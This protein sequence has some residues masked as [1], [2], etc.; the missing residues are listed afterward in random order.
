MVTIRQSTVCRLRRLPPFLSALAAA[1]VPVLLAAGPLPGEMRD[2]KA[3][4]IAKSLMN[5]MGGEDAWDNVQ[6]VRYDFIV[7]MGGK[8][9]VNRSHLWD[10]WNGRYRLESTTRDGKSQVV[11]FNVGDRQGEVYVDGAKIGGAAKDEALKRAYGAFINDMYWLA[12]PWKWLDSGV[13]LQYLGPSE[14]AGKVCDVVELSFNDVGLTPGDRYRAFVSPETHLMTRWEY[15]LQSGNKGA[16]SW[17]YGTHN[18][19]M[20]AAN[21]IN[22]EGASINMGEVAVLGEVEDGFFTDPKR[23]L[24]QLR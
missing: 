23:R 1:V 7:S 15:T 4:E 10:K 22:A 20:L 24:S 3:M 5:A 17:E 13:S 11:L 8:T 2:P 9:K 6:F 14:H 19:V 18:G 12:M 16:W 21:H